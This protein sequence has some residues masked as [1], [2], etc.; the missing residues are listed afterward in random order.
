MKLAISGGKLHSASIVGLLLAGLPVLAGWHLS[1]PFGGSARAHSHRSAN[2]NILL[3]GSRD[4]LLFRSD[5]A[6]ASWRLLPFSARHAGHVRRADHPSDGIR[7]FL[8]RPGCGRFRR[9]RCLGKPGRWRTL[10]AAGRTARRC[11]S[12]RWPC[13]A[14]DPRVLAAGTSKGVFLSADGGA[15]WQRISRENDIEMQDITALAFDPSGSKVIYAGHSRICR[16]R[17]WTRRKLAV[18]SSTD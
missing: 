13:G 2:R 12:N 5:D 3:V 14:V 4:S 1:G 17:P 18:D 11:A 8:R 10:A 6:A 16:G 7:A 9:L 15:S